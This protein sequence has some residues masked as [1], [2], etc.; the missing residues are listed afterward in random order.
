MPIALLILSF[1][2]RAALLVFLH[3]GLRQAAAEVGYSLTRA[4]ALWALVW[5]LVLAALAFFHPVVGWLTA[6]GI[7]VSFVCI[8]AALAGLAAT[9]GGWGYAVR[10]VPVR[11]G[12]GRLAAAYLLFLAALVGTLSLAS[13]HL[14][15]ESQIVEQTFDST[16]TI[17]I[18]ENLTSLGFPEEWLAL[19][20]EDELQ[21]LAGAEACQVHLD[22]WGD[23]TDNGVRYTDIQ[24]LTA[25]NTVRCYHFFTVDTRK[26]VLQNLVQVEPD[27]DVRRVSDVAGQLLWQ[28]NEE[29]YAAPLPWNVDPYGFSTA[30]FSYPFA[31]DDRRGWCAYTA[32][33]S[34]EKE[35]IGCS[36]LRYQTQ[37]L[38]NLYP[39]APLPEQPIVGM[40][41]DL[42]S[43][44]YS[45]SDFP[46]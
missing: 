15:V 8:L 10:A 39:Y 44:S 38:R 31:T 22:A 20:P 24:V 29:Q 36:I 18:R 35:T 17:A 9:L 43:Q 34:W 28:K 21:N 6:L 37:A 46:S 33:L 2:F 7:V 32:T 45:T 4:P 42:E 11:I 3:L 30:L 1:L 23:S 41:N 25:P 19:L 16:E 14:P 13:S 27:Q 26:A 5:N 12:D 40:L